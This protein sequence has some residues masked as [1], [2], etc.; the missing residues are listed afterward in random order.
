[1]DCLCDVASV[2][3]C[4]C[5]CVCVCVLGGE[6]VGQTDLIMEGLEIESHHWG[7]GHKRS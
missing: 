6:C 5:V 4:V 7:S 2:I 3:M 1:M